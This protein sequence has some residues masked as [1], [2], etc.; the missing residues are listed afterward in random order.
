MIQWV[1]WSARTWRPCGNRWV[2]TMCCSRL[3][4]GV[5]FAERITTGFSN[6]LSS[7]AIRF[8]DPGRLSSWLA[9]VLQNFSWTQKTDAI[10]LSLAGKFQNQGLETDPESAGVP[11][12]IRRTIWLATFLALEFNR[13]ATKRI[14]PARLSSAARRH[15]AAPMVARFRS[16]SEGGFHS[17]GTTGSTNTIPV[18]FSG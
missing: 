11:R 16:C 15:T 18:T 17:A 10:C 14:T 9:M 7:C 13:N 3:F 6:K 5:D 12:L 8:A 1:L 2:M 4:G